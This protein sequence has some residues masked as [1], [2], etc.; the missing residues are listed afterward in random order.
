MFK[1]C[2]E[3]LY[4]LL[5][6][7]VGQSMVMSQSLQIRD[8]IR[9]QILRYDTQHYLEPLPDASS[10]KNREK[11]FDAAMRR[12]AESDVIFLN[13][14]IG[15][16]W[17]DGRKPEYVYY[18]EMRA[19]FK[20]GKILVIYQHNQQRAY[21]DWIA[22][23]TRKLNIVRVGEGNLRICRWGREQV[24]AYFI[25]MPNQPQVARINTRLVTLQNTPWVATGSFEVI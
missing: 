19:L 20:A 12:T 14:D 7:L 11:W 18:R 13:P 1:V 15:M 22:R 6:R 21:R 9:S 25:V 17:D 2:D 5:Q 3:E 16:R 8:V 10:K 24:R 4:A 23:N